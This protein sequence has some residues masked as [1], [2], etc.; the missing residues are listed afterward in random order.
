MSSAEDV[1]AW[2]DAV[3]LYDDGNIEE[4][5]QKFRDVTSNS[6]MLFDIGCCYLRINNVNSAIQV[7]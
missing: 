3:Q 5:I 7:R 1:Q 6:K 2:F 4:A